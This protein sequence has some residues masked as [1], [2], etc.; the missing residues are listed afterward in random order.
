MDPDL[1]RLTAYIDLLPITSG[2]LAP[3][4]TA[5][6]LLLVSGFTSASRSALTSLSQEELEE[7]EKEKTPADKRIK[8]L[9]E[10]FDHLSI[11]ISLFKNLLLVSAI[12][13]SVY[14]FSCLFVA[15]SGSD[16][17]LLGVILFFAIMTFSEVFPRII[18]QHTALK[19]V[20]FSLKPIRLLHAICRPLSS[21]MV[22]LFRFAD[23]SRKEKRH[24]ISVDEL[25]KALELTSGE[26]K[27]DKDI[28]EGIIKFHDKTAV[29]IMTARIDISALDIRSDFKQVIQHIV[30]AGYSRTP[31]YSESLDAIKGVLYIKDLLPHID[32]PDNFRWQSLIR[33]AFFVPETKKIDDLLEEFRTNKIHLAIVVDEFGGTSGIVTLED[34]LEEIVGEISDEYDEED[35]RFT[36]LP[37]GS[38]L[39]EAKTQLTDFFKITGIEPETFERFTGDAETLAGLILEIKGSFPA[40]DEV[41]D[42]RQYS[43]RVLE[44]NQRRILKLSL[45][46]KEDNAGVETLSE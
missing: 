24:N 6:I 34:V 8:E 23:T 25:T 39:F 37:D 19:L 35:S 5:F 26:I 4:L 44:I 27:E 7:L 40:Q 9:L 18:G 32:R 13:L 36:K 14:A 31:V 30:D 2:A 12:V 1:Y 20:R 43:F 38:Y 22:N 33:P 21:T 45:R 28:L 42:Y 17:F 15:P 41:V 46:I 11:S 10:N 16:V 3:L 29:Q